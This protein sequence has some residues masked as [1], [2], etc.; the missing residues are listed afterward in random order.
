M[1]RRFATGLFTPTNGTTFCVSFKGKAILFNMTGEHCQGRRSG[2][3]A[4][5]QVCL[6]T[7]CGVTAGFAEVGSVHASRGT[8]PSKLANSLRGFGELQLR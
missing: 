5:W 3:T 8:L 6:P 7:G 2:T 1:D 4:D